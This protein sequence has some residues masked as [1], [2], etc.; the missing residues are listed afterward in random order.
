MGR[1]EAQLSRA[2][3]LCAAYALAEESRTPGCSGL[4]FSTANRTG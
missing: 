1:G 4:V 2:L 3:L